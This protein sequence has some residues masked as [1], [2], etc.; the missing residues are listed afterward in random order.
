[1][2]KA[3]ISKN[4][5]QRMPRYLRTLDELAQEGVMRI[6]SGEL[7]DRMGLTPSQIRQ[8]FSCFGGF[9]QQG[10]GYNV[11]TLREEIGAILGVDHG[12][13][14]ILVGIGKIGQSLLENFNFQRWGFTLKAAFDIRHDIIG[15]TLCGV[16]VL[17]CAELAGFVKEHAV[18]VA[19]LSTSRHNAQTVAD[20]LI[21]SGIR[22]IWNFTECEISAGDSGV[23]IESVH[24]SDSLLR[25]GYYLNVK[26]TPDTNS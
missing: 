15:E 18:D 16:P 9:G 20:V 3:N 11:D 13:S 8:D 14:M 2:K 24:F 26:E 1:M 17:D 21:R 7:G 23:A 25:L 5:I 19:V 6:S 10:Y 4:V 12:Y 22:A